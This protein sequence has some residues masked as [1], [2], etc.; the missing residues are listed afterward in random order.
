MVAPGGPG[1]NG[2]SGPLVGVVMGSES[3][4]PRLEGAFRVLEEL[5]IPHEAEVI[6]AHREPARAVEYARSAAERGLKVIV[7]AAGKA[8]ALPG[9]LA[10]S[11]HLPV[12]GLPLSGGALG[13]VEALLSV[14]ELPRGVPVAAVGIDAAANAALLAASI[15]ALLYP[16]LEGRL[17]SLRGL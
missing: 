3:D 4:R 15:L 17:R 8:A 5:G 2:A 7:A 11:T 6:S 10:G 9:V 14:S 1:I 16:E 13:G 12:V